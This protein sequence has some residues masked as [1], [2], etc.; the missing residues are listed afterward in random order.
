M[1]LYLIT[2]QETKGFRE[3]SKVTLPGK[4]GPFTVLHGHAPLL[5]VLTNGQV[6]YQADDCS[7]VFPVSN[8]IVKVQNDIIQIITDTTL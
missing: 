5:S 3:I 8:G 1:E 2:P 7:G 4:S 6:S